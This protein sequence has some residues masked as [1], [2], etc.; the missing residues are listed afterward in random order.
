MEKN[1]S[2]K[3]SFIGDCLGWIWFFLLCFVYGCV[4]D[5]VCYIGLCF[6][7]GMVC[8][9]FCL[10]CICCFWFVY[11]VGNGIGKFICVVWID[12]KC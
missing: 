12:I 8:C 9:D 6:E 3:V 10:E 1:K 4:Y 11:E 7:G 5:I 2:G